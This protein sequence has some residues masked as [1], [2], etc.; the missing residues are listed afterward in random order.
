MERR[1]NEKKREKSI[2]VAIVDEEEPA[3]KRSC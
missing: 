2:R 1:K 3:R